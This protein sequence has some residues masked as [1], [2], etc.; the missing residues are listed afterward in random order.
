MTREEA[1]EN[2]KGLLAT[3]YVDSFYDEENEAL[4]MAISALEQVTNVQELLEYGYLSCVHHDMRAWKFMK[5]LE[6]I[7]GESERVK[8]ELKVELNELKPCEDAVSREAVLNTLDNMDKALDENRTVK[9][10]KALLKECYKELPSVTVQQL[11]CENCSKCDDAFMR[12]HDIG[13]ENG[14]K[15]GERD[16]TAERQTG[17][18]VLART[19]PTKLYDEHI[20]EYQCSE[21]YRKIRCT[22]S[23]LVNYPFCHCGAK[24]VEPRESEE[25]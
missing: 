21:C 10:Y 5:D 22:E 9:E 11:D 12:G 3:N 19:F 14:Y 20:N 8:N 16:A 18:W 23:Q 25:V 2:L 13:L 4:E 15:Q 6:K 1:I 17:E 24:M 7:V